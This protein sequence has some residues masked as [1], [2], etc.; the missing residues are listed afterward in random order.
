[1]RRWMV[2]LG[3][4]LVAGVVLGRVWWRA[5]RGLEVVVVALHRGRVVEAVYATGRVDSERRAT[6]RARTAGLLQELT[7]GP[8]Q[9]VARGERVGRLD[10]AALRI[11]RERTEQELAAAQAA[12]AEAADTALRTER[13]VREGLSA[14]DAGVRARERARELAA[15]VR[16]RESAVALAREMEGWAVLRAPLDGVVGEI[17]ARPGDP[18]R[19]GDGIFT[20]VDLSEA[21]VRVAVDE[22]DVGRVAVG[23][24]VRMVFD[25]HPNQVLTGR[26]WR[27][28][29]AVDRLTKASDVL[30]ELPADLPAARLDATVTVNI[31]TRV[32]EDAL[33][34]PRDALEGAGDERVVWEAAASGRAMRRRITVGACDTRA[35]EVRAGLEPGERVISPLPVGLREGQRVRVP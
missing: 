9:A 4:V 6:A 3:I 22:R 8:A 33:V 7:V 1:M 5:H 2:L 27:L 14:E 32:V 11:A 31:V 12:Q 30:V 20:V 19:E 26:V 29:P 21:Y 34:V 24:E 16:A 15:S 23:Q 13:L 35:C 28:V 25:A 17:L 18:L 10:D